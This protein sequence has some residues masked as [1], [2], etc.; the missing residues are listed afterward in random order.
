MRSLRKFRVN[1]YRRTPP[2]SEHSAHR[3]YP[4]GV[5]QPPSWPGPSA[6]HHPPGP[7]CTNSA[8][9]QQ[10][11]R[12][13]TAVTAAAAT[14]VVVLVAA[15]TVA[16][17]AAVTMTAEATLTVSATAAVVMTAIAAEAVAM[18]TAA[19]AIRWGLPEAPVY[20]GTATA[21]AGVTPHPQAVTPQTF[22]RVLPSNVARVRPPARHQHNLVAVCL[23]M[24]QPLR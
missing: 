2:S 7:G 8:P 15:V 12:D 13:V 22:P 9:G 6:D 21:T 16:V 4:S 1:F 5:V 18:V 10:A 20:S 14:A 24:V 3:H 23:V 19:R 17:T 11:A